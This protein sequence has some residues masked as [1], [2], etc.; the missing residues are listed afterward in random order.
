MGLM[1][2]F[3]VMP[4]S[5]VSLHPVLIPGVGE[6]RDWLG[7]AQAYVKLGWGAGAR[8]G[9]HRD[10]RDQGLGRDQAQAPGGPEH[11]R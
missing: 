7:L 8:V 2:K 5:R 1:E 6:E 9:V 11:S 3:K 10:R 4:L